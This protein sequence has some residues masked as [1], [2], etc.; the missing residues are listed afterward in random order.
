MQIK[1]TNADGVW[2]DNVK[3]L[4]IIIK[5]PFWRTNLAKVLF[6]I[7]FVIIVITISI[8]RTS[9]LKKQ[10]EKL[11]V[12]V[13]ERTKTI[14]SQSKI[15]KERYE[16]VLSQKEELK[17]QSEELL[18]ISELLE[19]TNKELENKVKTRTSELEIALEK[20][21]DA[22]KLISSFLSNLSH[23]IRTPM[24]AI[25]GFSQIMCSTDINQKEREKYTEIIE[26][27]VEELLNQIDNIMNVAKLHS[28]QYNIVNKTFNLNDLFSE[29]YIKLKAETKL[30]KNKVDFQLNIAGNDNIEIFSDEES[31]KHIIFNLVE[32]ALKYTEKGFVEFGYKISSNNIIEI[33]VNDTGIGIEKQQQK[34]IFNAF[35]R[36]EDSKEKIYRG[37]GLGLALVKSLTEK[38]NGKIELN[39][40]LNEGT[41]FSI[42]IP[43]SF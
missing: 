25:M 22:E 42:F 24:N 31:Y 19:T 35:S 13:K 27:N 20:A 26:K 30:I 16:E 14:N 10:K 5:A 15:L 11:E 34:F 23:E 6:L 28:G 41:K 33:F 32:N 17:Q 40:K 18:L 29:L 38:L 21:K 7:L 2:N 36:I 37:T 12:Q 43:L 39:S 9:V 8:I 4:H 1:S 3:K